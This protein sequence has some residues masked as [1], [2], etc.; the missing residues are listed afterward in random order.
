[1]D[2][3]CLSLVGVLRT[4]TTHT[5]R[6]SPPD[7][8]ICCECVLSSQECSTSE[9]LGSASNPGCLVHS[10][11][12]LFSKTTCLEIVLSKCTA[13]TSSVYKVIFGY[14]YPKE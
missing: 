5:V 11:Y 2:L 4:C 10:S 1:M 7:V 6:T 14:I 8:G 12:F 9:F 3:P 13:S